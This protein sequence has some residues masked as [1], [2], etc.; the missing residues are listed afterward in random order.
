MN[1]Y[2]SKYKDLYLNLIKPHWSSDIL[3]K[4]FAFDQNTSVL[5]FI[6][7]SKNFDIDAFSQKVQTLPINIDF[8]DI[9]IYQAK[10]NVASGFSLCTKILDILASKGF[11]KD[12][13]ESLVQRISGRSLPSVIRHMGTP[14]L[15]IG[16]YLI[17]HSKET[18]KIQVY[19]H[20][21]DDMI[22]EISKAGSY[23]IISPFDIGKLVYFAMVNDQ[24]RNSVYCLD[25]EKWSKNTNDELTMIEV[26]THNQLFEFKEV[27]MLSRSGNRGKLLL[28]VK[29]VGYMLTASPQFIVI[30]IRSTADHDLELV[31]SMRIELSDVLLQCHIPNISP[32]IISVKQSQIFAD[33]IVAFVQVEPHCYVIAFKI[34]IVSKTQKVICFEREDSSHDVMFGSFIFV[35]SVK[36]KAPCAISVIKDG[37][38]TVYVLKRGKFL[39]STYRLHGYINHRKATIL[40][41]TTPS[42]Y[43]AA[44]I[45]ENIAWQTISGL[46]LLIDY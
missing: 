10:A 44:L 7:I 34:D 12:P 25:I 17:T 24:G 1:H 19:S 43:Q 32:S 28:T 15:T 5:K 27:E 2:V 46:M 31:E 33:K 45:Y 8:P 6:D 20:T 18:S 41:R 35:E 3:E 13:L 29:R 22:A 16:S 39:K 38:C 42:I 21:S 36:T 37:L 4:L 40:A 11:E 9:K 14:P 30:D 26:A 23:L